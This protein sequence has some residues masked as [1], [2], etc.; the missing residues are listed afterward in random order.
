MLYGTRMPIHLEPLHKRVIGC[1]LIRRGVVRR[2]V[3]LL[4]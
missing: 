1:R 2:V 3:C 4:C